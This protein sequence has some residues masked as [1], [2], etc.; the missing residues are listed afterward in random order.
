MF[1]ALYLISPLSGRPLSPHPIHYKLL[2]LPLRCHLL[3]E[4]RL[5]QSREAHPSSVLHIPLS[6]GETTFDVTF[7][8]CV[9]LKSDWHIVTMLSV[10]LLHWVLPLIYLADKWLLLR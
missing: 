9:F 2:L 7:P 3:Y 8:P 6:M 5:S 1:Q 4:A 10:Y